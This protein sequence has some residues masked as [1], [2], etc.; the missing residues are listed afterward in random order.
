MLQAWAGCSEKPPLKKGQIGYARFNFQLPILG[1]LPTY[2]FY[3][4]VYQS[5][6]S[7]IETRPISCK[8]YFRKALSREPKKMVVRNLW[9][10][11]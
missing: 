5:K 3:Y 4:T 11:K 7:D 6:L 10:H 8:S 1:Y 9:E 2:S